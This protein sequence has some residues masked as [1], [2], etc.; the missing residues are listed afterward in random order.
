MHHGYPN[1][2]KPYGEID[3]EI[4]ERTVIEPKYEKSRL[5][6]LLLKGCWVS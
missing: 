4:I 2:A 6:I 5:I 1:R 3:D